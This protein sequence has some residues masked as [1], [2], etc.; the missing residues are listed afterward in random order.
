MFIQKI[1]KPKLNLLFLLIFIIIITHSL[2]KKIFLIYKNSFIDRKINFAYDYCG[3]SSTGYIFNLKKEYFFRNP[4]KIINNIS[5]LNQYWIFYTN[6]KYNDEYII[7]LSN[8]K[9][10][11]VL[12]NLLDTYD[13]VNNYKNDCLLL[14]K[15]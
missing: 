11:K 3:K 4:P 1:K 8:Y 5:N 15:K 10:N 2:P 12:K 14:K 9:D 6:K 13:I 7:I